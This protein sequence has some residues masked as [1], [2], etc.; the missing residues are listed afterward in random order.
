MLRVIV[1]AFCQIMERLTCEE[2][3]NEI[4]KAINQPQQTCAKESSLALIGMVAVLYDLDADGSATRGMG[5]RSR[6]LGVWEQD[7]VGHACAD[8][9]LCIASV[10]SGY[11]DRAVIRGLGKC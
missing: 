10:C 8:L 5:A 11:V 9:A 1:E 6:R 4:T 3:R 2:G 7:Q